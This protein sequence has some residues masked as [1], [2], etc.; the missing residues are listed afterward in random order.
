[1]L[2]SAREAR[3]PL[4]QNA[5][6]SLIDLG[7]G[8]LA[9]ELH[10]KMNLIG[11][12][13]IAMITAGLKEAER[14]FTAFLI[15]TDAVN[16]SAGANLVLLL[17]EA[18]DGNWAEIDLMARTFQNANLALRYAAVPVV[19]APAGLALGGGCEMALHAD[20]LQAASETYIGL[21][22]TGVG[23]IPAGGGTKEM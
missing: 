1:L 3:P 20:R 19:I 17:L 7:D 12:D 15:S 5:G 16:F 14:S 2:R 9:L 10:S 18:Q 11:G 8:V 4:K 13:T 6:G 23:L 22:E 21:V